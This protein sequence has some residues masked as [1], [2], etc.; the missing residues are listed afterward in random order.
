MGILE[1]FEDQWIEEA[2]CSIYKIGKEEEPANYRPVIIIS[3]ARK[4]IYAAI[5]TIRCE[6]FIPVRAPFGFQAGIS[7]QHA[8]VGPAELRLPPGNLQKYY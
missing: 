2:L 4:I 5:F 1:T 6:A 7:V 8:L 3:H